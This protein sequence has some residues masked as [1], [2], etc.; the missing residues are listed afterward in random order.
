MGGLPLDTMAHN[1]FQKTTDHD[2]ATT[3]TF[4]RMVRDFSCSRPSKIIMVALISSP[5]WVTFH[6]VS[7]VSGYRILPLLEY[8]LDFKTSKPPNSTTT[9]RRSTS[10]PV[11]EYRA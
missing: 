1:F 9:T 2:S 4:D 3:A 10:T 8:R 5:G 7:H 11:V 6:D